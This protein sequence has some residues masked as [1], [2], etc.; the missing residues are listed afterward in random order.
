MQE[1]LKIHPDGIAG[2]KTTI[3]F[4][5]KNKLKSDKV[6]DKAKEVEK[7]EII[8]KI[9]E[10]PYPSISQL[11]T[12]LKA[13]TDWD[14]IGNGAYA[15]IEIQKR[16]ILYGKTDGGIPI[17]AYYKTMEAEFNSKWYN[18][19]IDNTIFI[20]LEDIQCGDRLGSIL[21]DLKKKT[22]ILG[23]FFICGGTGGSGIFAKAE[24]GVEST[25]FRGL[26]LDEIKK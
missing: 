24:K 6:Y 19:L 11:T 15:L 17:G 4:Y 3:A 23:E 26:L 7:L 5:E 16:K 1:A 25:T 10:V 18:K 9:L 2:E 13:I 22:T 21:K 12:D 14:D 8:K 20:N